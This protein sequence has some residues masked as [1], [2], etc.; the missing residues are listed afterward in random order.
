[1]SEWHLEVSESAKRHIK[2]AASWY[3]ERLEGL[4]DKFIDGFR[5][6]QLLVLRN[7]VLCQRGHRGYYS[8]FLKDFPYKLYYQVK[9]S[10][11]RVVAVVHAKR[12]QRKALKDVS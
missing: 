11:V 12:S 9:R 3:E 2:E 8:V 7:P 5:D 10:T 6:A 4:G 1:M